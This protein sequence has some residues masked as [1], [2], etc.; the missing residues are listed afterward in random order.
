MGVWLCRRKEREKEEKCG[1]VHVRKRKRERERERIREKKEN[2][3]IAI[4]RNSIV[5]PLIVIC[6]YKASEIK[7]I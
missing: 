5:T 2:F 4:G 1:C 3:L 7:E 6:A